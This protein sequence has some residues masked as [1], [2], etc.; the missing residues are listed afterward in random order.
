MLVT[1]LR[2]GHANTIQTYYYFILSLFVLFFIYF[3][4]AML[5]YPAILEAKLLGLNHIVIYT[6]VN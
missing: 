3:T 1:V 6:T 4:D 5:I 2:N